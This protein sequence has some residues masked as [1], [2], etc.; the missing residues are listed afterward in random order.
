MENVFEEIRTALVKAFKGLFS[1]YDV[2][3]E[4]IQR[5]D[6][7]DETAAVDNWIYID[8][9][10]VVNQTINRWHTDRQV[11]VDVAIHTAS[12]KNKAY[13]A[14]IPAVDGLIRPYF[15]FADRAITV[16]DVGFRIEDKVLHATF[17]LSFRD[18]SPEPE[19]QPFMQ[20]LYTTIK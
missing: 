3:C 12:E 20:E 6:S 14:I 1:A 10:P 9:R 2:F 4:E 7:A 5:T 17:T 11:F 8:M 15:C 13:Y 18:S 16:A 19:P